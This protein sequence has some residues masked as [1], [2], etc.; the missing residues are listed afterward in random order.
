MKTSRKLQYHS[1]LLHTL[2]DYI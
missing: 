1:Y 2:I